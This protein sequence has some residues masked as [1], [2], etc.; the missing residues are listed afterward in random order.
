MCEENKSGTVLGEGAMILSFETAEAAEAALP[1]VKA[2]FKGAPC[3]RLMRELHVWEHYIMTYADYIGEETYAFP[4]PRE[5]SHDLARRVGLALAAA[6]PDRPF[7]GKTE[8]SG[9]VP[10]EYILR[11]FV[12]TPADRTRRIKENDSETEPMACVCDCIAAFTAAGVPL[13]KDHTCP[14][15]GKKLSLFRPG[16]SKTEEYKLP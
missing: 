11:E 4:I 2:A 15:C 16:Q 1:A 12:Y 8:Y 7:A 3:E 14:R 6:A 10:P 5:E 13:W 9:E